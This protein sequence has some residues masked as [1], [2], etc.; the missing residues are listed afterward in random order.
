MVSEEI[1]NLEEVKRIAIAV[2]Q[3]KQGAWTKWESSKTAVTWDDL[4]Y[5]EPPKL[6]FL[7]KAVYEV[8]PT[9]VNLHAWGLTTSDRCRACG[10]TASLKHILTGCEYA[11][12]SY[13]WGHNEILK[14][15]AEA[16]KICCET[17]NKALDNITN[18]AIHCSLQQWFGRNGWA[19]LL[20][21][22]SSPVLGSRRGVDGSHRTQAARA[23]RCWLSSFVF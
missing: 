3:R 2:G 1:N 8:L 12:R 5:M 7:V 6:S 11:L 22:V 23:D 19:R 14:I 4:W 16:A 15:F 21:R 10:K 17:P 20:L 18:R 13:T 9:P